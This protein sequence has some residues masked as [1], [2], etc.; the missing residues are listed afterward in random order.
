MTPSKYHEALNALAADSRQAVE[1]VF[2]AWEG[3]VALARIGRN[4]AGETALTAADFLSL[5]THFD[6]ALA[7][8]GPGQESWKVA[9]YGH[10]LRGRQIPE[11]RCPEVLGRVKSLEA[12]ARAV[13]EASP[14]LLTPEEAKKQLLKHSGSANV[15]GFERF[16]RP[17]PLGRHIVWATF[18]DEEPRSDPFGRLPKTRAGIRTALGLGGPIFDDTLVLLVWSHAGSG[19]PP[20]H[21]P[22]IADAADDNPYFRPCADAHCLWGL[23]AP[24]APNPDGL[25]PQPEVVMREISSRGLLLPFRVL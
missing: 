24:L 25:V 23:T 20:L 14:G 13:S 3:D 5:L 10:Q 6:E 18:N 15:A 7:A 2:V 12:H 21:R 8:G 22:T 1:A 16:L 17:A 4:V 9:C 19:R 11:D